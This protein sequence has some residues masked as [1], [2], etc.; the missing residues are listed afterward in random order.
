MKY[1]HI[2]G[3]TLIEVIVFIIITGLVMSTL[4]V[5]A[6]FALRSSPEV[7]EQ[8]VALQAAR[9]CMEWFVQQRRLNG[10]SQFNCN[11]SSL[12]TSFCPVEAGYTITATLTCPTWNSDSYKMITVT[13]AGLSNVSLSTQ[14]GD[15]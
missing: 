9:G 6:T 5:G 14:F 2:Q 4:F 7:H 10:S 11:S 12:P 1:R 15:D 3:F 8:W 13:V